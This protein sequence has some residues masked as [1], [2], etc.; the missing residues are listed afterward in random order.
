MADE[1]DTTKKRKAPLEF[2]I[3]VEDDCPDRVTMLMTLR[4]H[5][6][7]AARIAQELARCINEIAAKSVIVVPSMSKLKM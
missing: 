1:N 4:L 6:R 5:P 3:G 2:D 7:D